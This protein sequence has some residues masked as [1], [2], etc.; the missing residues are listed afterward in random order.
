MFAGL[1]KALNEAAPGPIPL[2]KASAEVRSFVANLDRI[3]SSAGLR[4]ALAAAGLD[5]EALIAAGDV[6]ALLEHLLGP[7]GLD[8]AA[9]P[10][11]LLPFH[12]YAEGARTAFEEHLVEAAHT[13]AGGDGSCR[14]HFTVSPEHRQRFESL[15]VARREA[16]EARLRVRFDVDFSSQKPSTDTLGVDMRNAPFRDAAAV[17]ILRPGGHGALLENLNALQADLVA[18]K[19]ID[20][21][22]VETRLADTVLWKKLLGGTLCLLQERLFVH[23]ARLRA[24]GVSETD[25]EAALLFARDELLLPFP[26]SLGAKAEKRQLLLQRLQRPLRVCGMVRNTGEPGGGPY[27]VRGQDGLPSIQIVER[28]QI[29]A[30]S[31]AQQ[32]IFA[33]ATHFSPVDLVCGLRDVDGCPYDLR[34]F[35]DRDAVVLTEKSSQGR[36]LRALE[37]PGLWNGGMASWLTVLVEV[38]DT[39][40]NP[41]KTVMDLLR[42]AHQTG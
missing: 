13:V 20:N 11:G 33:A 15:F 22:T 41:V 4:R 32:R 28:A 1:L 21:V 35:V 42:P 37:H 24:P 19:N 39:T 23:L 6:R 38:P 14:L 8:A 27:W 30:G 18:I 25:V 12:A 5:L 31:A 34:R 2:H 26:D 16:L 3:A 29:D 9:L 36:K 17:L 7:R 40:F 10:K